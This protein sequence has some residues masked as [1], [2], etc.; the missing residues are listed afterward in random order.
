MFD[1]ETK[2]AL[3]ASPRRSRDEHT[4]ECCEIGSGAETQIRAHPFTRHAGDAL[5]RKDRQWDFPQV[6]RIT[7]DVDGQSWKRTRQV[8]KRMVQTRGFQES[9]ARRHREPGKRSKNSGSNSQRRDLQELLM[10]PARERP[11]NA[12]FIF[13]QHHAHQ[14]PSAELE[15]DTQPSSEEFIINGIGAPMRPESRSRSNENT[16]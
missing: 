12:F 7:V 5:S 3:K 10:Q 16:L 8:Q 14:H 13:P 9:G 4:A 15:G 11:M 2:H 6:R 1:G